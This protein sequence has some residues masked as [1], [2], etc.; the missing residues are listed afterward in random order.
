MMISVRATVIVLATSCLS[1]LASCADDARPGDRLGAAKGAIANGSTPPVP[2]DV[3]GVPHMVMY[4]GTSGGVPAINGFGSGVALNDHWILTAAHIRERAHIA[5]DSVSAPL[6][7]ADFGGALEYQASLV[8]T[9]RK[10]PFNLDLDLVRLQTPLA[11]QPALLQGNFGTPIFSGTLSQVL[12]MGQLQCWGYGQNTANGGAGILR[13]ANLVPTAG[14]YNNAVLDYDP[15]P[16]TLASPQFL[17]TSPNAS[18]QQ[19][20]PG[21][22]GGPCFRQDGVLVGIMDAVFQSPNFPR[23]PASSPRSPAPRTSSR[24]SPTC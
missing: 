17:F 7:R 2:G 13:V 16:F 24:P 23:P 1:L 11:I 9:F 8:K 21:D 10:A 19:L 20:A 4:G 6:V 5:A 14:S 15:N 18:H 3:E 22:S 12:A